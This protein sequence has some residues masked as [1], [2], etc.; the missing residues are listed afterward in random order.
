MYTH[1][2]GRRERIVH[3]EMIIRVTTLTFGRTSSKF[4]ATCDGLMRKCSNLFVILSTLGRLISKV[5]VQNCTRN[6]Q[7]LNDPFLKLWFDLTFALHGIYRSCI[8]LSCS[9]AAVVLCLFV[10]QNNTSQKEYWL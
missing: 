5:A 10:H 1:L 4:Q 7:I 9:R 8:C 2:N 6:G 3:L